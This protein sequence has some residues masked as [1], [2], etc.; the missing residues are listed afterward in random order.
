MSCL[1]KTNRGKVVS[2][3]LSIPRSFPTVKEQKNTILKQ[4]HICNHAVSHETIKTS[5]PNKDDSIIRL[6]SPSATA[7]ENATFHPGREKLTPFAM[8]YDFQ[9]LLASFRAFPLLVYFSRC[10]SLHIHAQ[11]LEQRKSTSSLDSSLPRTTGCTPTTEV[12]RL[13]HWIM[14]FSWWE[15]PRGGWRM[16]R[17]D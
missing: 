5:S 3:K 8:N 15:W 2:G 12:C 17:C 14:G 1:T 10:P 16:G 7:W 13:L 9:Q 4:K 11:L 6:R